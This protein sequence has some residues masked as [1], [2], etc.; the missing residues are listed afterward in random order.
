MARVARKSVVNLFGLTLY[1]LPSWIDGTEMD[2]DWFLKAMTDK[3][4]AGSLSAWGSISKDEIEV[5]ER[6]QI[7]FSIERREL[8]NIDDVMFPILR[9]FEAPMIV[10]LYVKPEGGTIQVPCDVL[11]TNGGF[12]GG[13]DTVCLMRHRATILI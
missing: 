6:V 2:E 8:Y 3:A 12:V 13:H 11:P 9:S 4:L 1:A 5:S 10:G 7:M